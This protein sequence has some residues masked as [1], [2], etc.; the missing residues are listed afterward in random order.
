MAPGKKAFSP[1][2]RTLQLTQSERAKFTR[3]IVTPKIF[4]TN[5]EWRDKVIQADVIEAMSFLPH[6][7]YDLAIIDPPYYLNKMYGRYR[8]YK[9]TE[10]DYVA[11]TKSWILTMLPLLK[12]TASVYVCSDWK[13]SLLIAPVLEQHFFIQ[14]RITWEREKGRGSLKNWKNAHE[15]IWFCTVS[16]QYLFHANK[17]KLRKKVIAPYKTRGEPKDWESTP[18]GNFR[19]TGASNLFTDITIPYWS[20]PENTEHPT[21]KPEKLMAKL[22]LASSQEGQNVLDIFSGSGTSSV[23]SYKLNRHFTAIES[24]PDYVLLAIKRLNLA[25]AN[26]TIQ[27]FENQMFFE[28]NSR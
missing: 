13:T 12:S 10:K 26:K 21:Q 24:N 20:M 15:D 7:T 28:R 1:L 25:K 18:E 17:V 9:G 5:N 3:E 27:G 8:F 23:T 2:N 11:F 19:M 4:R 22:V 6:N 14:N 16:S